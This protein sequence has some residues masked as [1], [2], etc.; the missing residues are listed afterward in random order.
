MPFVR[1]QNTHVR[2][3]AYVSDVYMQGYITHISYPSLLE[4]MNVRHSSGPDP[5]G[6]PRGRSG[7]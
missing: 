2:A 5:R 6:L 3:H 1:A 7:H 4:E